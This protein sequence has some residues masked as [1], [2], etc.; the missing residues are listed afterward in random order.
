M[1]SAATAGGLGLCQ[2]GLLHMGLRRPGSRAMQVGGAILLRKW[3]LPGPCSVPSMGPL[4]Q[5]PRHHRAQGGDQ[6]TLLTGVCQVPTQAVWLRT[7]PRPPGSTASES[8]CG[9]W[10]TAGL[11]QAQ[12]SGGF[13]LGSD[14]C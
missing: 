3:A 4:V 5:S 13:V 14:V 8:K 11:S 10:P 6:G 9:N 2:E 12:H 1:G 7:W